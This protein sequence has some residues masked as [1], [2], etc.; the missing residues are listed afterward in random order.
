M[1]KEKLDKIIEMHKAQPVGHGYIDIIVSRTNYKLFIKDLIENGFRIESISWWEW[2]LNKKESKFGLGGPES[3]YYDGWFSE[4]PIDVDD[5]KQKGD[6]HYENLIGEITCRIEE[7][8]TCFTDEIVTFSQSNWLT[9]AIWLDVPDDW[10]NK[11]C[12]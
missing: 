12:A 7:K 4:L 5:L 8:T 6:I 10:R 9:P 2:C 1:N 3:Y 11:Y